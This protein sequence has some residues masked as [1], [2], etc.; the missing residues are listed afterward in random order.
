[1]RSHSIIIAPETG[2][3]GNEKGGFFSLFSNPFSALSLI[4]TLR[5][6]M[7]Q[8]NIP[9]LL[10]YTANIVVV[11]LLSFSAHRIDNDT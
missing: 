2:R 8:N 3:Q 1:M 9:I 11:F 4:V 6:Y 10:P 7:Q 5:S